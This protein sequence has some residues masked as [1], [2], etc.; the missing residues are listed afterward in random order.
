MLFRSGGSGYFKNAAWRTDLVWS[1]LK[2]GKDKKGYFEFI[3]NIDYSW[4]WQNKNM[5]GLI[6]YYHN[7]LGKNNYT[8]AA[9]DP[10]IMERIDRGELFALGKNYLSGM[11]QMELHPLF[12]IYLSVIT[13][14]RD[15]SAII[16]P[17]AI[18][19]MTQNSTLHFGASVFYGK[20]GSEYGGFLIP[21]TIFFTNADPNAYIRFTYYF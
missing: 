7:G 9:G 3:V 13:N 15:P 18:F 6:E 1:T 16:Q 19:S 4:V 10:E 8:N 2:D 5:Y 20:K 14:I 21:G 17:W 12:N 11:I